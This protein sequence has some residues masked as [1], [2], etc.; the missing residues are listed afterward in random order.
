MA[1]AGASAAH[2]MML[3]L[4]DSVAGQNLAAAR[5]VVREYLLSQSDRQRQQV[6]AH[7]SARQWQGPR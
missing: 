1:K 5:Q 2:A 4:E 6:W 7:Q 3:D